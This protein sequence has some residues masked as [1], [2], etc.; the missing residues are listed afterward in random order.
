MIKKI[1]L[2]ILLYLLNNCSTNKIIDHHG[3]HSLEKKQLKLKVSEANINDV[4]NILGPPS[5]ENIFNDNNWIYIE[6]KSTVSDLKSLGKKKLIVNNVLVLEFD[7]RGLLRKKNFY[8]INSINDLKISNYETQTINL[9]KSTL[10]S[11][12][13]SLKRKINDPLGNKSAK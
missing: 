7:N 13:T 12:L 6:R 1:I 2:L 8:D 9:E 10:S 5:T 11:I 4:K 3:I